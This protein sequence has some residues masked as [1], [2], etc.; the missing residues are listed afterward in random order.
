MRVSGRGGGGGGG[1]GWGNTT[2]KMSSDNSIGAAALTAAGIM[3]AD[4]MTG[5]GV[6]NDPAIPIALGI[7][8]LEAANNSKTFAT[9]TLKN[10]QTG[11]VYVGRT[12]GFFSAEKLVSLRGKANHMK[13]F[14]FDNPM[15]DRAATGPRAYSA[16]RGRGQQMMDAYGGIGSARLGNRI[17][18]ISPWNPFRPVYLE[19]STE[20]F[21]PAVP[22]R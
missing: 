4:D 10:E 20:A 14:G 17:N 13:L 8:A 1:G 2:V 18:G 3:A 16:I 12:S 6:M 15:L 7:A 5:F 21:G 9:Y 11:K 22:E 19:T